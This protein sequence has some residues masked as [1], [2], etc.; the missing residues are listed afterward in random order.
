MS[1]IKL[2]M[3]KNFESLVIIFENKACY[4]SI[5]HHKL[6]SGTERE[7]EIGDSQEPLRIILYELCVSYGLKQTYVQF[8]F[9]YHVHGNYI[10]VSIILK[11]STITIFFLV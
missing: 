11:Y 8:H 3:I 1:I 4:S 7:E 10:I 5:K 9:Y 2:T 6:K